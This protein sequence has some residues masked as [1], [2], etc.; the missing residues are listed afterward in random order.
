MGQIYDANERAAPPSRRSSI[1]QKFRAVSE[2]L[3]AIRKERRIVS[4]YFL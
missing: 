3:T 4:T 2:G 1:A